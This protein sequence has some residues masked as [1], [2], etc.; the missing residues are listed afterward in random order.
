MP[1][2]QLKAPPRS[3]KEWTSTRKFSEHMRLRVVEGAVRFRV[4]G[5]QKREAAPV[6]E[7]V[8]PWVEGPQ[9]REAAPDPTPCQ[10]S[11]AAKRFKDPAG[12]A[13]RMSQLERQNAETRMRSSAEPKETSSP[14]TPELGPGVR[15]PSTPEFDFRQTVPHGVGLPSTPVLEAVTAQAEEVAAPAAPDTAADKDGKRSRKMAKA[16]PTRQMTTHTWWAMSPTP[17][18]APTSSSQSLWVPSSSKKAPSAGP[19]TVS[20]GTFASWH[21]AKLAQAASSSQMAP[22][23]PAAPDGER[24][25]KMAR[26]V[27]LVQL[28]PLVLLALL[29]ML[30][31]LILRVL[32]VLLALRVQGADAG[33]MHHR[34]SQA[35]VLAASAVSTFGRV[36]SLHRRCWAG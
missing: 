20:D 18:T 17:M 31:L 9:K 10:G 24:S 25:R 12:V 15:P 5:P 1:R 32:P 35:G 29:V 33:R 6:V 13:R 19:D 34:P 4:E 27:L 28:V 23:A 36:V 26:V 2:L 7:G 14:S 11:G 21:K 30:I 22:A 3:S 16:K 8:V